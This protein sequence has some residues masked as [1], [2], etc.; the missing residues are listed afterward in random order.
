MLTWFFSNHD[1]DAVQR[2]GRYKARYLN[3]CVGSRHV[4]DVRE[5]WWFA[6]QQIKTVNDL[7]NGYKHF[8]ITSRLLRLIY[9]SNYL[10]FFRILVCDRTG[11]NIFS[12]VWLLESLRNVY[13]FIS[14]HRNQS[15]NDFVFFAWNSVCKSFN[16]S[17][18]NPFNKY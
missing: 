8:K 10:G 17:T 7:T 6:P 11:F 9:F 18:N 14:N 4:Q 1:C 15:S 5:Q 16:F 3:K 2:A 12:N 13:G